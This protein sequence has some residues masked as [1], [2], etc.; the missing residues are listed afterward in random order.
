MLK[1]VLQLKVWNETSDQGV[2]QKCDFN[3]F[4]GE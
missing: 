4:I 3:T 1:A 2:K